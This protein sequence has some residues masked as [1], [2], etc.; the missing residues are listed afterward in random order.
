MNK[1]IN[2]VKNVVEPRE[3]R[4]KPKKRKMEPGFYEALKKMKLQEMEM[5]I[6]IVDIVI[7]FVYIIIV[8]IISYG[9]RNPNSYLAKAAM[10]SSLIYGGTSCEIYPIDDPR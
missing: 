6:A 7:Y 8:F 1:V 4:E 2:I 5:R 9:N 3:K 10:E